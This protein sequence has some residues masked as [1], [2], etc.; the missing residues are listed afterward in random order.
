MRLAD[1]IDSRFG[2]GGN[3]GSM[4][5]EMASSGTDAPVPDE[6]M[7]LPSC[8]A[9]HGLGGGPYEIGPLIDAL[10]ADG[11]HVEAPLLPGHEPV[12]P[13]MPAS[14][15]RDWARSSEAAFDALAATGEPVV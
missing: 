10:R 6:R 4:Q 13:I 9:L 14:S 1:S 15:W 7:R 8:L 5:N 3:G 11:L 2:T 12:S